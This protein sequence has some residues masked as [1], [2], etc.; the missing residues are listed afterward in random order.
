MDTQENP[1][2]LEQITAEA[3]ADLPQGGGPLFG[4]P[5]PDAARAFFM[6]KSR[7]ETDKRMGPK[8]AVERFITDGCYLAIGGF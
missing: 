4:D 1:T 8:E 2:I 3:A 7:A 6:E 5:D